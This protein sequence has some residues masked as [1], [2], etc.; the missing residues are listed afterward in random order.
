MESRRK[1]RKRRIII[2]IT[3]FLIL[4]VVIGAVLGIIQKHKNMKTSAASAASSTTDSTINATSVNF[5]SAIKAVCSVTLHPDRCYS[6][7]SSFGR[8]ITDTEKIFEAS[9]KTTMDVL[10]DVSSFP[11]TLRNETDDPRVKKALDICT[12]MI[13]DSLDQL[14][15]SLI[16]MAPKSGE[17]ISTEFRQDDLTTWLSA[18]ISNQET[19]LDSFEGTEGGFRE[20]MEVAMTNST[21]LIS[22]S[23]AIASK[24]LGYVGLFNSP[25]S[26]RKLLQRLIN[27]DDDPGWTERRRLLQTADNVNKLVRPNIIVA[28][29]GTGDF[30]TINDALKTVPLKSEIPY[31]IYI[32]S[33][34]YVEDVEITKK[35]TS[36][37]FIGD[38]IDST[39]ISGSKNFVDGTPTFDTATLGTYVRIFSIIACMHGLMG[40]YVILKFY[41]GGRKWFYNERS[42][43]P[44]YGRTGEAPGGSAPSESR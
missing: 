21:E 24:V 30:L 34:L 16:L 32:K 11:A 38:G 2:G 17:Q 7:I 28:K 5:N 15:Q 12:K 19:C 39:V 40:K 8:N 27:D 20:K 9:V 26:N 1:A 31:V 36:V 41:S 42:A 3:S 25:G 29:D 6:T 13:D 43:R 35:M 18:T 44:K 33:G 4:L 22:N 10:R 23:L 14:N 37:M